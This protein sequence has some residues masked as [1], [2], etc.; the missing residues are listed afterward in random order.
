[1]HPLE[2]A[3]IAKIQA[4]LPDATI[5]LIN[6]SHRHAG[7]SG[8]NGSGVSH[9]RLSISSAGFAGLNAVARHRLI[10]GL[11]QEELAGPLHALQLDCRTK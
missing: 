1:M 5:T 8:D 3:I 10:Y 4:E 6:D 9:L 7:H 2:Q 11:L